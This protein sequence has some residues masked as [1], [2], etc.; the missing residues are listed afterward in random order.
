[1]RQMKEQQDRNRAVE[2]RR[3]REIASLKKDQRRAE[4]TTCCYF[5]Y[6]QYEHISI[7]PNGSDQFS[8]DQMLFLLN[9]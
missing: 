8:R 7:C 9:L 6:H 5:M 2:S 3:N 4:V 1:M